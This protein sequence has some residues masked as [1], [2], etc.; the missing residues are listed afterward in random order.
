MRI[1]QAAATVGEIARKLGKPLHRV[2]YVIRT[3]NIRPVI[4]A[5]HARIFADADVAFIA[6]ELRRIDQVR[7]QAVEV[8]E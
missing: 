6:S 1:S 7:D 5:G 3:R 2:E 8:A 4:W